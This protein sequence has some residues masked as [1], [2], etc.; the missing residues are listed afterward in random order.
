MRWQQSMAEQ[1]WP[2]SSFSMTGRMEPVIHIDRRTD[3]RHLEGLVTERYIRSTNHLVACLGFY[4]EGRR[5]ALRHDGTMADYSVECASP[6]RGI[7]LLHGYSVERSKV[8]RRGQ[9]NWYTPSPRRP[10]IH[11]HLHLHL[12]HCQFGFFNFLVLFP[13]SIVPRS[14]SSF[15]DDGSL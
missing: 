6:S 3:V 10:E 13:F 12:S 14:F 7:V 11:L 4:P 8:S 1:K 2:I 15:S 5:Q 9:V